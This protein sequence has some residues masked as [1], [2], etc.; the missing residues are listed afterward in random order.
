MGYRKSSESEDYLGWSQTLWDN[1][2]EDDAW[3]VINKADSEFNH[4]F[5]ELAKKWYDAVGKEYPHED[6]RWVA[7]RVIEDLVS[8]SSIIQ[9]DTGEPLHV[10]KDVGVWVALAFSMC[11]D[12]GLDLHGPK[13]PSTEL[14]FKNSILRFCTW[15]QKEWGEE[16]CTE[17]EKASIKAARYLPERYQHPDKSRGWVAVQR[18]YALGLKTFDGRQQ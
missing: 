5:P 17:Y 3:V 14:D 16:V 4:S 11:K 2:L 13:L 9:D 18:L 12:V 6:D 10:P 8:D 1:P 7:F 15:T